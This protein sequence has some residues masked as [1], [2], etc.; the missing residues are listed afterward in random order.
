MDDMPSY[1][2]RPQQLRILLAMNDLNENKT[3]D[4]NN[5]TNETIIINNVNGTTPLKIPTKRYHRKGILRALIGARSAQD[6]S[7]HEIQ[8]ILDT[9]ASRAVVTRGSKF[10]L[11]GKAKE[12]A[13]RKLHFYVDEV[14]WNTANKGGEVKVTTIHGTKAICGLGVVQVTL[15]GRTL[16]VLAIVAEAGALPGVEMLLDADTMASAGLSVDRMLQPN[17]SRRSFLE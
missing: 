13:L 6:N 10:L 5:M 3:N 12:R 4:E 1:N 11:K 14:L 9:G 8:V 15:N 2:I 16:S 7:I 17:L